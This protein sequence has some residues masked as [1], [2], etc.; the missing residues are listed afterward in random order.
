MI[1]LPKRFLGFFLLNITE[2]N[3]IFCVLAFF[4]QTDLYD[5]RSN[6]EYT[7]LAYNLVFIFVL[8]RLLSTGPKRRPLLANI[9]SHPFPR[10]R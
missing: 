4:N 8:S 2:P 3:L 10:V 6:T 9:S 7:R 5:Q 1:S